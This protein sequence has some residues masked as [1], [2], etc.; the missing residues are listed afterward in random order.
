MNFF[1]DGKL[2][3]KKRLDNASARQNAEKMPLVMQIA[4]S[5]QTLGSPPSGIAA[6]KNNNSKEFDIEKEY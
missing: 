2:F 6:P 3:G 4:T 5:K 1:I